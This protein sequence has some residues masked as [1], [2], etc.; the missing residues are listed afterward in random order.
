MRDNKVRLLLADKLHFHERNFKSLMEFC[1]KDGV[2]AVNA[3]PPRKLLALYGNYS[4]LRTCLD[5]YIGPLS[6]LSANGLYGVMYKGVKL[7]SV[8]K[9][10]F[11]AGRIYEPHWYRDEV[12]GDDRLCFDLAVE[13]DYVI[14]LENMAAAMFWLDWW[15]IKLRSIR[16]QDFVCVFSGS[17]IYQ[18]SLLELLKFNPA[19]PLVFESFFTGNEY[20]CERKYGFIPNNSDLASKSFY[21]S[22]RVEEDAI[23]NDRARVKA[24]NKIRLAKNKNVVQPDVSHESFFREEDVILIIG[25]V[26]NDFSLLGGR[27][28]NVNALSEYKK[29]VENI[30]SHTDFNI[31]FK[32]HPWERNKNPNGQALVLE[33]MQAFVNEGRGLDSRRIFFAENHNL[34]QLFD[35]ASYVVTLCSQAALEAAYNGLKPLQF[36]DAFY[37]GKGFTYDCGDVEGVLDCLLGQ[38]KGSLTLEEYDSFEVF[39]VRSLCRHLISV[40]K[41]GRKQ[42]EDLTKRNPYISLVSSN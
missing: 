26:L 5:K 18:R 25:Q 39:C 31:I 35:Q 27:K 13:K 42:L 3:D 9:M 17:L 21:E 6:A 32:S 41:S 14:L 7:F 23:E 8:V 2:V 1:Q 22:L 10:E 20:Y 11:L 29:L 24:I 40:H 16:R 15:S 33:E 38:M 36:G 37:G 19:E 28:G 30:L 12:P 34:G 4:E